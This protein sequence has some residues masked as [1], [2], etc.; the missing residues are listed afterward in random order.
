M[1]RKI[2]IL[3]GD[4]PLFGVDHLSQERARERSKIL[5]SF[6]KIIE[7]IKSISNIGV[8]GFVVSTY[9]QLKD[10]IDI[11]K[12]DAE[13]FEKID[14]YPI[15]PYAQGYVTKAT[16]KGTV[17]AINDIL[18]KVSTQ[19]KIKILFDG[20]LGFLKKDFEKLFKT[21]VDIELY[22]FENVR[23]KTI[24]LHDVL[25]D[26]A[27]SLNMK[28][29]IETFNEYVK[30][31]YNAECGLVTKN[32]PLLITSLNDWELQ[33][34]KVMTS[35]NSIGFQMNPSKEE[36]EK[37]LKFFDNVI[38]MNTLA[39]GFLNPQDAAKYISNL[40]IKSVV[41]GMSNIEHANETINAFRN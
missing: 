19:K 33:I 40:N 4:N 20:S 1:S 23:K 10:L 13:L 15:L 11:M 39:G 9:P 14:F 32:F 26:I 2:E 18:S 37:Y 17:G 22:P 36:C 7:I 38:A 28:S 3:L 5:M 12:K 41:I 34:P 24:F 25:T 29:V 16:E 21:F 31:K 6:E 35:F 27:I 8:N 30:D